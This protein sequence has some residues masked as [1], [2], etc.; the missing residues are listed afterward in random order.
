LYNKTAG[1]DHSFHFQDGSLRI[2]HETNGGHHQL[3]IARNATASP[4]QN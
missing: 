1:M 4:P 3:R 2:V